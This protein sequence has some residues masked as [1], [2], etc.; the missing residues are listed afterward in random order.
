[1]DSLQDVAV[2]FFGTRL[3]PGVSVTDHSD[4][5]RSGMQFINQIMR[6]DEEEEEE[7]PPWSPHYS[8]WAHIIGM[9]TPRA[10]T[11]LNK[12]HTIHAALCR[13]RVASAAFCMTSESTRTVCHSS[14]LPR[15]APYE[16]QPLLRQGAAVSQGYPR[17]TQL[18]ADGAA[19]L[20]PEGG[21]R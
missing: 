4:G 14:F 1:M 15:P 18:R 19:L 10:S 9:A 5:L 3:R 12:H 21:F 2:S 7:S 20:A 6:D 16:E 8:D 13:F 17:V 11:P